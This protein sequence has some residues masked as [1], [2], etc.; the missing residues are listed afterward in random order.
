MDI[1]ARSTD[2]KNVCAV[3][4]RTGEKAPRQGKPQG[5]PSQQQPKPK[6][7][8]WG[9]QDMNPGESEATRN[10]DRRPEN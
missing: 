4:V 2:R 6:E 9:R 1:T 5:G 8:V 7:N 3:E 10:V